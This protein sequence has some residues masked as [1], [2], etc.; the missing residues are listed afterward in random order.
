MRTIARRLQRLEEGFALGPETEQD[1][2]LRERIKAAH[3]RAAERRA[4][5][6]LPPEE[7]DEEDLSGLTLT[8]ILHRGRARARAK[9]LANYCP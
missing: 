8:E 7:P 5:E 2:Q 9:T 4:R 1:R 3:R 6:G